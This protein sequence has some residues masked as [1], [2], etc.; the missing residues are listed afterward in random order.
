[1]KETEA[2]VIRGRRSRGEPEDT[3]LPHRPSSGRRFALP[4]R[5]PSPR[6]GLAAAF[7]IAGVLTGG[8]QGCEWR[9]GCQ[10]GLTS[11]RNAIDAARLV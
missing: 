9:R 7:H 4:N 3:R 1:M 11:S 8:L 5:D 2:V 6:I 10:T